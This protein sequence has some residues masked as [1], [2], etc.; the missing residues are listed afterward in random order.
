MPTFRDIPSI[1]QLR[2]RESVRSLERTHGH[3]AVVDALRAETEAMRRRVAEGTAPPEVAR[4]IED[5]LPARLDETTA[6]SLRPVINA[7]GV[8]LHT[9]LGRAP[10]AAAAIAR[11]ASLSNGYTNLEYD[12]ARGARGHRDV[13]AE[14]LVC[15][16]TGAASAVVVNNNAAAT[17]LTLAALAAGREVL[18][19]R[20]E[21]VEIG[22]GFRIPD[23]M[24]QSG[25]RLREVGTTNRTRIADYAAAI[26]DRT[27][28][29]LRVHP[30]NFRIQGFTER[31]SLESLVELGRRFDV[32]VADDVGSGYVRLDED[33]PALRN[34]PDVRATIA[35]GADVV[36]FS[37]D[38][39]LGGPQCGV[40]AGSEAAVAGIRR[41]PLMRALR[42]D[43][44]TLAALEAT[45]AEYA[46][47]RAS[48]SVPVARM[49]G[50]TPEEIGQR[51]DALAARLIAAGLDAAVIDGVSTI[52]GGSA[53]GS[54]LP[55]R[56][57]VL[58][59]PGQS[60]DAI[61]AALRAQSPAVIAR[62][63]GDRVLLDLRTVRPDQDELLLIRVLAATTPTPGTIASQKE[64]G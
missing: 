36:M 44:L 15:R 56:V 24:A 59:C 10:L 8:I 54:A 6:A 51:A 19:S 34:E 13:H 25:A 31:P 40:I 41:H 18:V 61:E 3:R 23:V 32:P 29:I 53:P 5:A 45:L 49:I 27:G 4:A 7:T 20:G 60:A 42:V 21:L 46:A 26:S 43:K 22:G 63:E 38:K 52:G 37:G 64:G 9:N 47:G 16:I 30:S 1:E 39:L 33:V 55:T 57:V 17:L 2:Q 50:M 62:I 14:R 11:I 28:L 35:A 12:I 58:S 48:Q